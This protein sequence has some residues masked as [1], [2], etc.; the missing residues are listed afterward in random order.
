[1]RL[2]PRAEVFIFKRNRVLCARHKE[3]GHEYTVFP[4]GG[5]D[6]GESA[7]SAAI[8][9]GFE[10]AG[11]R[12]INCTVAHAPSVQIWSEEYKKRREQW[13]DEYEGSFTYWMTGSS[14]DNP[15]PPA[16][17]HPDY[18]P[19]MDWHPVKEVIE[20]LKKELNGDWKD[21]V[22]VRL[23]VLETHLNMQKKAEVSAE[24]SGLLFRRPEYMGPGPMLLKQRSPLVRLNPDTPTGTFKPGRIEA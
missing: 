8:R 2:R 3:H 19:N 12:V 24:F 17:R 21:D 15:I 9:E 18:E 16:Y 14:S 20:Q 23:K 6:S 5:V 10:E 1:M 22:A 4:G 11:R 7:R 13:K